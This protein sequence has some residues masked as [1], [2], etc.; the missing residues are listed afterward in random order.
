MK[1]IIPRFKSAAKL[2]LQHLASPKIAKTSS[3]SLQLGS[4]IRDHQSGIPLS[5]VRSSKEVPFSNLGDQISPTI[6]A[7]LTRRPVSHVHFDSYDTRLVAMGTIGHQQKAGTVHIWGTGFDGWTRNTAGAIE[8][9]PGFPDAKYV[10]HALRG[11]FSRR[12]LTNL[13]ITAPAIFGDPAWFLPRIMPQRPAVRHELGVVMHIVQLAEKTPEAIPKPGLLKYQASPNDNIKLISTFHEP[14]WDGFKLKLEEILSCKRII[15]CSLHGMLIA[16][17]Y[18]IPCAFGPNT[19]RG[20][21][22]ISLEE[23]PKILDPR[24]ADAYA[25]YGCRDVLSYGVPGKAVS[26]WDKIIRAIDDFWEPIPFT[27][28]ELFDAFPLPKAVSFDDADWSL[29]D[30]LIRDLEW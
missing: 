23:G 12:I 24:F 16:E 4:A 3:D 18:G 7:A 8:P 2:Y 19:F 11:P 28:R 26:D 15:S 9:F 17:A 10:A 6:V 1:S 27:G 20:I 5:W 13:G 25:G 22:R 14:T 30:R 29:P 21:Q